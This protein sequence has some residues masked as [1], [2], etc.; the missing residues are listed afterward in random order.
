MRSLIITAPANI[1]TALAGVCEIFRLLAIEPQTT[2]FYVFHNA[3]WDSLVDQC[4]QVF[5]THFAIPSMSH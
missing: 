2:L 1:K 3:P 4:F 5:F